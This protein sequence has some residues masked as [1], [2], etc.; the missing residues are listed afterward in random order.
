MDFLDL[1]VRLLEKNLLPNGGEMV[2]KIGL[3]APKGKD[4]LPTIHFRV[5]LLLV[6]LFFGRLTFQPFYGSMGQWV[7]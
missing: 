6:D 1:L 2:L 5:L 7:I 4:R 3:N